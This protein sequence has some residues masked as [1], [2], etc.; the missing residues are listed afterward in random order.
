MRNEPTRLTAEI[1]Q[2]WSAPEQRPLLRREDLLA[3]LKLPAY[4]FVAW[5]ASTRRLDSLAARTARRRAGRNDGTDA[6]G[7]DW[8]QRLVGDRISRES[9]RAAIE[10][11]SAHYRLTQL[12]Y[13]RCLRPWDWRPE[14]ELIGTEHLADALRHGRGAILWTGPF[15]YTALINKAACAAAG[16]RLVQLRRARHG[17]HTS[18]FGIHVLNRLT[19]RAEDR[20][21]ADRIVIGLGETAKAA[22]RLMAQRLVENRVIAVAV[23]VEGK[24]V[25]S[26]PF[27][28]ARLT[29]AS[30]VPKL[31]LRTG[32][33]ILPSFTVR[34]A[35]GRF[36]TIIEPPLP[37]DPDADDPVA[38]IHIAYAQ[39]LEPYVLRYPDQFVCYPQEPLIRFTESAGA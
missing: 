3:L 19:K 15:I 23:G 10:A 38:A 6:R 12:L 28:D 33:A 16:V 26:V 34:G 21:L 36:R 9:L 22:V 29:V 25:C 35:D 27:L 7:L 2:G 32:A 18:T 20:F 31:A 5:T 13:L 1:T 17:R 4:A 30:G 37:V 24:S 11:R 14:V 8:W 39:R